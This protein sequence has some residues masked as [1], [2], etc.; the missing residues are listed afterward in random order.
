MNATT[1]RVDDAIA[2]GAD[3]AEIKRLA[4]LP[5]LE[6]DRQRE[7]AAE[8]L[9]VRASTLDTAVGAHRKQEDPERN[10]LP[11]WDVKPWSEKVDGAVLLDDLR[12]QFK[13]HTVLPAYAD[14]AIALWVLHTWV[15]DCFDITPYLCITSPTKRCGKTV[16]M[17]LLY[18]L[19]CRGKKND[20]M[21]QAAIYR[22]VEA[23]KPT[24][25]LDEVGWVVDQKDDRQGILCGGFERNGYV[26]IC[27]GEK[28]DITTR[29]FSTYCPKAFGLIGKLTSTLADRGITIPMRRKLKTDE[30]ARLRRRDSLGFAA[31]RQRCLRWGQ[32]NADALS[33]APPVE[34]NQLNDRALD[35]WEP[36]IAIADLVGGR[37]RELARTAA[38]ELN[39]VE[40]DDGTLNVMLL[41]AVRAAFRDDDVMRSADLV[42]VLTADPEAP[43]AEYN[44]GKP[45]TQRQVA[46]LMGQFG[47]I[48][49]TV[50][51]PELSQGKG[52]KRVD[53]EPLWDAYCPP[54]PGHIPMPRLVRE[55]R[56]YKRT[57]VDETGT[58]DD[59]SSVQNPPPYGSKTGNLS[60][61]HA[62]LYVCTDK[63]TKSAREGDTAR[64]SGL[65]GTSPT[66]AVCKQSDPP[67]NRVAID[68]PDV[69]LHPVCEATYLGAPGHDAP[70][71]P[72]AATNAE[73][74]DAPSVI[75]EPLKQID[76]GVSAPAQPA[77]AR[78]ML[79]GDRRRE[80]LRARN[81]EALLRFE[82]ELRGRQ[83]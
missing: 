72:S 47:V 64:V 29:R 33:K 9:G 48:S 77:P 68:G 76:Q 57:N 49:D 70:A 54:D 15:F 19:C 16:L 7:K 63:K 55:K 38:L 79:P 71:E 11:H 43:W 6:Y 14:V 34:I 42:A 78:P 65:N 81:R 24:L 32:D 4:S 2:A 82:A 62:G 20:S 10:F 26:E 80:E 12:R 35:F 58:T 25:V 3:I 8:K 44:R 74:L 61:S 40:D 59:F 13:L 50:H 51:P 83:R 39:G 69:W 5:R 67:P 52:Y 31:L 1:K 37:W 28:T 22:S 45:I 23:E 66:C 21:S 75:E 41:K 27:E 73:G 46:K 18:F 17:T 53:L 30:V 56:A 36:L 60:Y